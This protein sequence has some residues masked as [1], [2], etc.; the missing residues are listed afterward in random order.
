MSS[1]GAPFGSYSSDCCRVASTTFGGNSSESTSSFAI[2]A[3]N[4][5]KRVVDTRGPYTTSGCADRLGS[6]VRAGFVTHLAGARFTAKL[7]SVST[8]ARSKSSRPEWVGGAVKSHAELDARD[9]EFWRDAGPAARVEASLLLAQ[10]VYA[11]ATP[12]A[13]PAGLDRTAFGVRRHRRSVLTGGRPRG[14]GTR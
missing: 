3:A 12:D 14:G 6:R 9:S 8:S 11:L 2:W 13:A 10:Q 7:T 1:G 5:S 4:G